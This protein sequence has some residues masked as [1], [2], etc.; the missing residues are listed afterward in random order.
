MKTII[1][2]YSHSGNTKALA[3]KKAEE[4]GA[5]IEE[6]KEVKSPFILVG[7]MRALRQK[8]TAIRP[9]KAKLDSYEKVIIMGPIWAAHPVSPINSIIE[10]L[11]AGKDV[12]LIMVSGGGG[13]QK[14]AEATKA[15]VVQRGCIVANY[16]DV[17]VKREGD[18]VLC[19]VLK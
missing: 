15:L 16:I 7:I 5:D 12:E 9:I 10:C 1:L 4:L 13:S 11:P 17:R 18:E 14:S 19:E 8:K 3:N 2:Y 6:I